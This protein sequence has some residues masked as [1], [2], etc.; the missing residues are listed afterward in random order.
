VRRDVHFDNNHPCKP[1]AGRSN[2][3]FTY[4]AVTLQG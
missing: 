2:L 4:S 3:G 1:G